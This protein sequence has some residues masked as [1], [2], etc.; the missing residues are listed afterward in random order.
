MALSRCTRPLIRTTAMSAPAYSTLT[1]NITGAA[2]AASQ[3]IANLVKQYIVHDVAKTGFGE[4]TN[5]LY[6]AARPSYPA[7]ALKIIHDTLAPT[8]RALKIIEP[9]SGTGIFSRLLLRAPSSEYPT[10]D[11]DTLVGVEP[12]E[13]MRNSWWR[14]L[15]KAG[16]GKRQELDGGQAVEGRK[17]GT[18]DGGFDAL[19]KVKEY[20]LTN[21][22]EGGGVDGVI[23]A[24]AWHWCPDHAAALREIASFLLPGAPLILIWNLESQSP[25]WQ[26][27]LRKTYQPFDLGSP[28]YYKGWWRKMFENPVYGELFEVQE[29]K[30][31]GWSAEMTEQ[32][33]LDR[34]LSKSYL[35]EQHLKGA[36]REKLVDSLQ[37]IIHEGDK[38]WVDQEV[39]A[40]ARA[41]WE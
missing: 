15:E 5:D 10:F 40:C 12:S 36:E 7:D 4:G 3:T 9:G 27:L 17:V 38:D 33:V 19:G 31:V 14:E 30:Q 28:Q 32:G 20:G 24:Q 8:P 34:L 11:I 2:S 25:S 13:G 41:E 18:V 21:V 35:T 23:I 6:N 22:R 26:G 16:L 1:D 29:E 37:R 39:R